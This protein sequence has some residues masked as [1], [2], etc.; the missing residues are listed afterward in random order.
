MTHRLFPSI[1]DTRSRQNRA[2][3]LASRGFTLI[4]LLVVIAIIA[5]LAAMLLPALSNA[6]EKALRTNCVSNLRQCAVGIFLYAGDQ[7]DRLPSIKFRDANSW[8]P[9]EMTRFDGSPGSYTPWSKGWENLGYLWDFK[10]IQNAKVFYCPSNKRLGDSNHTYEWYTKGNLSWPYG[11][12]PN[13][14][15]PYVRS[16]YSYFPQSKQLETTPVVVPYGFGPQYLPKLPSVS[17]LGD[18]ILQ[19]M[20]QSE[21]D[22]NRSMVVDLVQSSTDTIT[23]RARGNPAGLNAGFG[24]GHV[25]WQGINKNPK[26][27]NNQLWSNIGN[28]GPSYRYAMSLWQP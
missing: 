3:C 15:N 5:I 13:G 10:I 2:S 27:F 22:P 19:P 21:I 6:K 11:L 16:G 23:H 18:S 25:A 26:A 7:Q 20:K 17:S 1:Y 4:E 24:D 12:V 8:Y 9:Y 14:D 28:D